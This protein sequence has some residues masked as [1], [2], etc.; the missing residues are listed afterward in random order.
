ML[1]E[2]WT[3]IIR[4][5]DYETH[6][7]AVGQ[8]QA[9]AKLVAEYFQ[10]AR[11]AKGT[12]IL[13]LGAGT[14]QMFDYV[15][16]DFL[17]PYRT[18]FAD[19][20]AGY[21][22]WLT[23]RLKVTEGLHYSTTVDD[24][25][26]TQ[27]KPGAALVIAVLLLEHVNWRKAVATMCTLS[28]EMVLVVVQQ[29]PMDMKTAMTPGRA[30]TGTMKILHELQPTLI[31]AQELQKAFQLQDFVPSYTAERIAADGK[32]MVALGFEKRHRRSARS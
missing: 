11:M 7:A 1:R 17:R 25:E 28:Q 9:T 31:S 29:N 21:L 12:R 4:A 32:K 26:Q 5:E 14:G 30:K 13:F 23:Q 22:K 19:I 6:M 3:R 10:F 16:P 15:T 8:A 18:T 20:N 27:L 24:V 2:A